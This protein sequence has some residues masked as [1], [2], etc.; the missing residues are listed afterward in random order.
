MKIAA[1]I[2]SILFINCSYSQTFLKPNEK[3]IFSFQ[4][5]SHK[6]VY[7]VKDSS[8]KYIAYRY[9]TKDKIE[10]EFPGNKDSSWSK[11]KYSF[12]LRGGGTAN[13]GMELNY[14]YFTN[15]GYMYIIYDTYYARGNKSG[16]GVKV[17]EIKTNK[18]TDIKG[19]HK[20]LKGTLVDFRDNNLLEI[21]EELFD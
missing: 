18:T 16:I 9:G 12:Y 3:V 8:D 7:L 13:E 15:A 6:Q 1:T 10:F 2:L 4:T 17:I 21:G 19:N 5:L 14:V 11:F 20:T